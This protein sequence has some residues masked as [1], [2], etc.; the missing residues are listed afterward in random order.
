[1]D[2]AICLRKPSHLSRLSQQPHR[3]GRGDLSIALG[4]A[5]EADEVLTADEFQ[6]LETIHVF[7]AFVLPGPVPEIAR[8]EG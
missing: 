4:A 1:L 5:F 2:A 3:G 6:S 7:V 8:R